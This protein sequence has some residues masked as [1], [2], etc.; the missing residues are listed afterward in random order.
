M[1]SRSVHGHVRRRPSVLRV[2][3]ST[4][5][6][7]VTDVMDVFLQRVRDLARLLSAGASAAMLVASGMV[8]GVCRRADKLVRITLVPLSR[9][10][11]T[12]S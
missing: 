9:R 2:A 4:F 1:S 10:V 3:L 5:G 12:V 7:L 8:R 6:W 11:Q